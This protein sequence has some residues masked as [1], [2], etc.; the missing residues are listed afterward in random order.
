MTFGLGA[1]HLCCW[2]HS[3]APQGLGT[4]LPHVSIRESAAC[5]AQRREPVSGQLSQSPYQRAAAGPRLMQ[6]LDSAVA[7]NDFQRTRKSE[8]SLSPVLLSRHQPGA[9]Q[10]SSEM[11][12]VFLGK[13]RCE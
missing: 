9:L 3:A 10:K 2:S 8:G 6:P 13:N 11:A 1:P 4:C 12:Q 7:F 5:L